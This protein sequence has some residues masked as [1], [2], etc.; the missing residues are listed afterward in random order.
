V[1]KDSE[2]STG[3]F[4]AIDH[5]AHFPS[6]WSPCHPYLVSHRTVY[7]ANQ[8]R[9]D[10]SIVEYWEAQP[11]IIPPCF[12]SKKTPLKKYGTIQELITNNLG[13]PCYLGPHTFN[14]NAEIPELHVR[15]VEDF[16]KRREGEPPM[17]HITLHDVST[18]MSHGI[19]PK[20]ISNFK[21]IGFLEYTPERKLEPE[22]QPFKQ[23]S[24]AWF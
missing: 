11:G 19:S 5:R 17:M 15:T 9:L 7:I 10:Y 18:G 2:N 8:H 14:P 23:A 4:I 6:F 1:K 3:T 16:E 20:P 12:F 22:R 24:T 13:G 21:F